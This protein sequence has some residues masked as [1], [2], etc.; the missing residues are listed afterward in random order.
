MHTLA[1]G[2]QDVSMDMEVRNLSVFYNL[3]LRDLKEQ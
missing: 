2:T 1:P 3:D